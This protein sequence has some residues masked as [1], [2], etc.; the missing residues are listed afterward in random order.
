MRCSICKKETQYEN[1]PFRPFCSERCKM[2]DLGR[3]FAGEYR[4]PTNERPPEETQ[5]T[6][7]HIEEDED[8]G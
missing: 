2:I 8:A 4:V 3:W 1:N 6:N 7:G 5:K